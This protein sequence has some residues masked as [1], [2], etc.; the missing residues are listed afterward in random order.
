[1]D[2]IYCAGGNVKLAKIA[3]AEGFLYGARSDDIR[4]IRCDGLIDINWK[5]YDWRLHLQIVSAH[6]PKYAVAPD[7]TSARQL[8][9]TLRLAQQLARYCSRVIVVPKLGNI[10]HHIPRCFLI[11][12]SVPTSYSGFLPRACELAGRE[13]HL[14]G[15]TPTQQRQL[16]LY[17]RQMNVAV[18]SVDSNSHSKASDY[19]SYWDGNRWCDQ[20]RGTIGKYGAFRKSCRGI[21]LM[22]KM[23]GAIENDKCAIPVSA[24]LP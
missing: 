19:G 20:E 3:I 16:W 10:I 7:I 23:L 5:K 21:M 14:L 12:I 8:P 9:R 6:H 1:M 18:V 2:V 4:N 11:G 24:E 17:F 22:W 13:V 15:G